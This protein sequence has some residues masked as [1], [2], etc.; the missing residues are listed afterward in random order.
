MGDPKPTDVGQ[1]TNQSMQAVIENLPRYMQAINQQLLPTAQ[2]NLSTEQAISPAEQALQYQLFNQFAPQYAQ[3]QS[4]IQAQQQQA[5][6]ASNLASIQ[7]AGGQATMANQALQQQI[8]PEYYAVRNNSANKLLDLLNNPISGSEQTAIERANS[9]NALGGGRLGLNTNQQTV[10]NAMNFGSAGRD[11]L[12]QA[13][14][15]ATQSLPGYKSGVDTFAQATGQ[16][17][18]MTNAQ[19][20]IGSP[21]TLTG[22]NQLGQQA[23]G[24]ATGLSNQ[25]AATSMNNANIEANRRDS[26]DRVQQSVD[27]AHY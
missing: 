13:L 26:L 15:L 25:T 16:G 18:T 4:Q 27:V 17:G 5:Q 21:S 2:A 6:G 24:T 14:T 1:S 3:T 19:N 23:Y 9:Q 10:S 11:R 22:Q 8:D 12:G 7:G 20:P